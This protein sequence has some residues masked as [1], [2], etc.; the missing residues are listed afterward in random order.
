[1]GSDGFNA[2]H[3]FKDRTVLH[4][5]VEIHRFGSFK[6]HAVKAAGV[7]V[8]GNAHFKNLHGGAVP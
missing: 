2:V 7:N 5:E 3:G 1:M 8:I 4:R 6:H